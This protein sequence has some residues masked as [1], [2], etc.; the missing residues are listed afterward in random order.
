MHTWLRTLVAGALVAVLPSMALA[1]GR[2]P[3]TDSG[4]VGG[5]IGIFLPDEEQLGSALALEGFYEYYFGPRTSLRIGMGWTSPE[6][7]RDPNGSIRNVRIALDGV[8]NWEGGD[9]HPFVG[10]G[11]GVYFLQQRDRGESVG[12]SESKFG[13][14]IF[15]GVEV[16]TSR[17]VSVKGEARYHLV[18]DAGAY[19]PDGFALSIGLKKYF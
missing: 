12:D 7:D 6:F 13:G 11:I 18:A 1:Q 4:A 5:D 16:F 10:A 19:D 3:R 2:V 9:V 14:T 8:Y 17:T 15:G